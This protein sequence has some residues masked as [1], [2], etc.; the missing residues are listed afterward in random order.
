MRVPP[1]AAILVHFDCFLLIGFL[2]E[3]AEQK[4]PY[5]V[6]TVM[7]IASTLFMLAACILMGVEYFRH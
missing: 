1:P 7:L 5:N 3:M 6:Y 2:S 4:H